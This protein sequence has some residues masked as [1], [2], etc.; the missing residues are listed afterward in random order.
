MVAVGRLCVLVGIGPR[1][2]VVGPAQVKN[3]NRVADRSTEQGPERADEQGD[4]DSASPVRMCAGP[5]GGSEAKTDECADRGGPAVALRR[6]HAW[7]RWRIAL[8]LR[9]HWSR[10]P[11]WELRWPRVA[12][13][14]GIVDE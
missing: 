10:P 8:I 9:K 11:E 7:I 6:P 4:P 1:A 14:A 12:F 5:G 2:A 13:V 3:R